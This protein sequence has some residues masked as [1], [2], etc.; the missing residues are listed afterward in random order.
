VILEALD[1][2]PPDQTEERGTISS[3][4]PSEDEEDL[5]NATPEQI[6]RLRVRAFKSQA[7]KRTSSVN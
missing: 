1:I 7:N 6:K 3:E 4:E 5:T 2:I